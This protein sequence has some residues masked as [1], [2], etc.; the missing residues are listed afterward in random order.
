M[1][2][3]LGDATPKGCLNSLRRRSAEATRRLSARATGVFEFE[4]FVDSMDFISDDELNR[5]KLA[6]GEIFDNLLL[7]ALP[8]EHEAVLV[9]AARRAG[10]LSLAFYFKSEAFAGY[11]AA[12]SRGRTECE[13]GSA[14]FFDPLIGRWRGIGLH[15]CRNLSKSLLLRSGPKLDRIY[16]AF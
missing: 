6:G 7:H 10:R 16:I 13:D 11:A 5:M 3:T 2:D 8:L 15:M 4:D 1:D 9:R 12:F 14:P